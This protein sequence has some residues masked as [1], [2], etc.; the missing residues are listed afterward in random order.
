MTKDYK[1]SYDVFNR[2]RQC[3]K[4]W[5]KFIDSREFKMMFHQ[6][7]IDLTNKVLSTRGFVP[8]IYSHDELPLVTSRLRTSGNQNGRVYMVVG[9]G[10]CNMRI[11]YRY[12]YV[13]SISINGSTSLSGT[14]I[15][16]YYSVYCGSKVRIHRSSSTVVKV[17]SSTVEKVSDLLTLPLDY[18]Q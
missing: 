5:I 18:V 8:Y 13:L 2:Y 9:V 12:S 10:M 3:F 17:S 15:F 11:H 1:S 7:L 6:G 16:I 14:T 4:C